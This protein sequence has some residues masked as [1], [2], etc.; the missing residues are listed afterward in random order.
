[1]P[2]ILAIPVES[3]NPDYIRWVINE[4]SEPDDDHAP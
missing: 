3:G 4:T 2:C 1:V